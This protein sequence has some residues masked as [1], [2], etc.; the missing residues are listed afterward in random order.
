LGLEKNAKTDGI[1]DY[2]KTPIS[3]GDIKKCKNIK[4]NNRVNIRI[5]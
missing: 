1:G 4:L 5:W 2:C 3:K